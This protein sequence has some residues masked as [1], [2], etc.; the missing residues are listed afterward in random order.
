MRCEPA[1]RKLLRLLLLLLANADLEG[2]LLGFLPRL[3]IVPG[4]GV[5]QVRIDVGIL[6]KH[7]HQR[8][9][10]IAGRAKG[11]E[12]LYIRKSHNPPMI[13]FHAETLFFSAFSASL[14]KSSF[15][16]QLD[17]RARGPEKAIS[18]E[19][20]RTQRNAFSDITV[21]FLEDNQICEWAEQRGLLRGERFE[22]RLPELPLKH[23]AMYAEGQRSGREGE[24]AE[25]L[26]AGLGSWD[27]C[28][29]W[30]TEWGVWP[31]TAPGQR[32]NRSEIEL[33]TA[34]IKLI[35]E[36]AWEADVLCSSG[37]R[38]D[39]VRAKISHDEWFEIRCPPPQLVQEVR[40]VQLCADVRNASEC[41]EVA[42]A[43]VDG[44]ACGGGKQ[45]SQL[46]FRKAGAVVGMR[47]I[48]NVSSDIAPVKQRIHRARFA[49]PS[50][51]GPQAQQM[52]STLIDAQR[53]ACANDG[54]PSLNEVARRQK[55]LRHT[56]RS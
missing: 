52:S 28:L 39:K 51:R 26:V 18:A 2:R 29:V 7:S 17:P 41:R 25:E 34:L 16:V 19:T 14:R 35:M 56:I 27:E 21:E 13:T 36:N 49:G 55:Q 12:P 11:P 6:G 4:Y 22:V 10:F 44:V 24:A 43:E 32:F 1:C 3:V 8:E 37:G 50:S 45:R 46:G 47:D 48:D 5:G 53:G 31:S 20:Q 38:A 42:V 30:S 9:R 40:R 54:R 33:L 15:S 23:R